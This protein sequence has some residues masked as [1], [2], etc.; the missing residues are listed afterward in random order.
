MAP[1]RLLWAIGGHRHIYHFIGEGDQVSRKF[2]AEHFAVLR[3]MTSSNLVGC[4]IGR[5]A[6]FAPRRISF[7]Y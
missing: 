1:T 5:S 2:E 4:S 7:G 6:G 3:L